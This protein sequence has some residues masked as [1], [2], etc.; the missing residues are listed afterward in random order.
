M[1]WMEERLVP[2]TGLWSDTSTNGSDDGLE[3]GT[4]DGTVLGSDEGLV[5]GSAE[6][7]VDSSNIGL[8]DG[9]EDGLVLGVE[10]GVETGF[11]GGVEDSVEDECVEGSIEGS[12]LGWSSIPIHLIRLWTG[13][14]F[15]ELGGV[16]NLL[17][18]VSSPSG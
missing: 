17:G 6:G 15:V 10:D 16:V 8:G 2:L 3:V 11:I 5:L 4:N 14:R 1:I 12:K 9:I 7:I 18:N 13:H